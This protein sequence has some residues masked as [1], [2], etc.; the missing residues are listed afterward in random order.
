MIL[1][2]LGA[3]DKMFVIDVP[4]SAS[5]ITH[6]EEGTL[7][8]LTTSLRTAAL[9]I[10]VCFIQS[11]AFGDTVNITLTSAG[12]NVLAGVY[13]NPYTATINGVSSTVICDDFSADTYIGESWTADV[14][15][16]GDLSNTKFGKMYGAAAEGLYN[17]AAWLSLQLLSTSNNTVRR[18][19]SY[20]IWGTMDANAMAYLAS[21]A[22]S[23]VA[24]TTSWMNQA[25]TQT[26]SAGQFSNFLIYTP[27]LNY[28]ITCNGGPCPTIPPQ[29]LLAIRASESSAVMLLVFNLMAVA[30]IAVVFRRRLVQG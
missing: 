11:V 23:Y 20:A 19:I 22:P 12:S 6:W 5:L 15:T 3:C 18:A 24:A 10:G 1:T 29:E 26:F 14:H 30:A 13:V 28:P 16:F 2:C 21:K 8:G 4:I 7:T 9:V 17:Q 27:N 25:Q